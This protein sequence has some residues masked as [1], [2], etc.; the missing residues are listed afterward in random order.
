[1]IEPARR[2]E[3]SGWSAGRS[4]ELGQERSLHYAERGKGAPVVLIHGAMLDSDDWMMAADA[5]GLPGR[6]IAVDRPGHGL[7]RRPRFEASVQAQARQLRDGLQSLGL[8]QP[9]LVG[10]S[11]GGAVALAYA[12]EFPEEVGGL[13]LVAPLAFP[14]VRP[15]EHAYFAPRALALAG[16]AF[17]ANASLTTDRAVWPVVRELMFS[18]QS[19]SDEWK[20]SYP[21]DRVMQPERTVNEGEDAAAIIPGAAV[22]AA[23]Y[24]RIKV[25]AAVVYGSVD[26]VAD[27]AKHAERLPLVIPHATLRKVDGAGHMVHHAAPDALREAV[28]AVVAQP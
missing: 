14:E 1:M 22:A 25:P 12:V 15:M 13:V 18:P 20:A 27:P 21:T 28:S 6:L 10:H 24:A 2:S 7:S 19:P 23:G 9:V 11:M 16:P 5:A 3:R 17:A 26:K 8:R 4:I